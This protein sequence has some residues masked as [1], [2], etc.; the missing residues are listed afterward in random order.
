MHRDGM[1]IAPPGFWDYVIVAIS[2]VVLLVALWLFLRSFLRP[3]E[4]EPDHI[5]R[6]VLEDHLRRPRE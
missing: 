4:E 5:K 3:G 6:K 1:P 2:I